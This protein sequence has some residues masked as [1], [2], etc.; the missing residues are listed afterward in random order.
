VVITILWLVA[1]WEPAVDKV[2]LSWVEVISCQEQMVA[3][4]EGKVALFEAA[5]ER[6]RAAHHPSQWN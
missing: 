2:F 1:C 6:G 3:E 4:F 5:S